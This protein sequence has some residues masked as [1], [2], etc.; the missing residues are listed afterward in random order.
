MQ[1]GWAVTSSLLRWG[2]ALGCSERAPL[3]RGSTFRDACP[4]WC[5]GSSTVS[6]SWTSMRFERV[7]EVYLLWLLEAASCLFLVPFFL[8]AMPTLFVVT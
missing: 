8:R 4:H 5:D 1:A 6:P 2:R 3:P 7:P